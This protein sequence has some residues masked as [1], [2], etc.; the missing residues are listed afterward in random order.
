MDYENLSARAII[1]DVDGVITDTRKVHYKAWK[2]ILDG[3][4]LEHNVK[5]TFCDE[6]YAKYVDGKL[7]EEG[8]RSFLSSKK[9]SISNGQIQNLSE[10]KDQLFKEFIKSE[11][12]EVFPDACEAITKWRKNKIP[13]AAVSSSKNSRLI[14]QEA[15]LLELFDTCFDGSEGER[16]KLPGKPDP[17]YF[18]E[19]TKR[20]G[21]NTED[22]LLVEDAISGIEAGK[23]AHFKEVVGISR[24][25]QTPEAEL[26][27]AGADTTVNSLLDIGKVPHGISSWKNIQSQIGKRDVALFLDF[28]GTLS[29]IVTDPAKAVLKDSLKEL[30]RH[31]SSAL[32]IAI[33]SGRDRLDVKQRIGLDN[34]FYVGSHGLDISGPGCFYYIVEDAQKFSEELQ[35][36]TMKT[37]HEFQ[38]LKGIIIERKSFSTAIHYRMTPESEEE[39][40]RVRIFDLISKYPGLKAKKGKKVIEIFPNLKWGKGEAVKKLSEILNINSEFTLPIYIGDDLTDEDAFMEIRHKGIGIKVHESGDPKTEARYFLKN[41]GEVESFLRIISKFYSGENLSWR[42]GI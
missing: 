2:N 23:R 31:C 42:A 28:D 26:Y 25:G 20:L 32:K 15:G 37:I 27:R 29:E 13:L 3:F 14:L 10:R 38:Q 33:M 11:K 30:I 36:A 5:A 39:F 8:L 17:G 21:L 9:I 40:I 35:D 18:L 4:L 6:D 22:C 1:L 34:I 16:L 41:P 7:R 19:A 12:P 24:S